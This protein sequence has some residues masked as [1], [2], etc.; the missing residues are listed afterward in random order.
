MSKEIE[1]KNKREVDM[2]FNENLGFQFEKF[3]SNDI[4][5][6][7]VQGVQAIL[8]MIKDTIDDGN[9]EDA[10]MWISELQNELLNNNVR[11]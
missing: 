5:L 1:N 3:I 10:K 4:I 7:G 11:G 2:T 6:N 9:T 8:D